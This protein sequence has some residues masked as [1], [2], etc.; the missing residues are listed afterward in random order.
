MRFVVTN[1]C[2]YKYNTLNHDVLDRKKLIEH[3]YMQL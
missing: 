1:Y 2:M 3:V